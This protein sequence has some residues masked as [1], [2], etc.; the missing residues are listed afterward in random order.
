MRKRRRIFGADCFKFGGIKVDLL[1]TPLYRLVEPAKEQRMARGV[2][3]DV[4]RRWGKNNVFQQRRGLIARAKA[5]SDFLVQRFDQRNFSLFV[6][7]NEC[8][9]KARKRIRTRSTG[10]AV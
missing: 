6:A 9:S 5:D 3:A 1:F 4:F 8:F 10:Q 7:S 2:D